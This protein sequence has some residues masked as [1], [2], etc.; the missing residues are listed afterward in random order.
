MWRSYVEQHKKNSTHIILVILCGEKNY[1]FEIVSEDCPLTWLN[2]LKTSELAQCKNKRL[3]HY[4]SHTKSRTRL[5]AFTPWLVLM[6]FS[7]YKELC[8]KWWSIFLEFCFASCLHMLHA[9]GVPSCFCIEISISAK[10]WVAR[11]PIANRD[12]TIEGYKRTTI[13]VAQ[14]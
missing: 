12:S 3:G 1:Q 6:W 2:A 7:G 11:S 10:C 4:S 9:L 14:A 8:A 5:H 13:S